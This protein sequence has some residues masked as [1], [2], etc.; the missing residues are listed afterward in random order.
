M[1]TVQQAAQAKAFVA[2]GG[3]ILS[4]SLLVASYMIGT[5]YADYAQARI[6]TKPYGDKSEAAASIQP[7]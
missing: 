7:P 6:S 5:A 4:L 2:L 1:A 3:F